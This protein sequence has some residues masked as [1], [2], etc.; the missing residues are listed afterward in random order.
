MTV[1][2]LAHLRHALSVE[3]DW[4]WPTFRSAFVVDVEREGWLS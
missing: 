1:L 4:P 3:V 2:A